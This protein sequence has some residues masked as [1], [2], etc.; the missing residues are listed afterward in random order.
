[1]KS[2][3]PKKDRAIGIRL[4]LETYDALKARADAERRSLS[5]YVLLLIERDIENAA[6]RKREMEK[7]RFRPES[8]DSLSQFQARLVAED[9][10]PYDTKLI[11]HDP[12]ED[13]L[14]G[15]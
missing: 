9:V 3:E 4:P 2:G 15:H 7:L 12:A 1:M 14:E 13:D 5:N 10:V 6:A 8:A 11:V